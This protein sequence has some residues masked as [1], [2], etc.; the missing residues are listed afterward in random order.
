MRARNSAIARVLVRLGVE[1]LALGD[2]RCDV[3]LEHCAGVVVGRLSFDR[4]F[5]IG[6]DWGFERSVSLGD[7]RGLSLGLSMG[8][9][10]GVS[11][12]P[13]SA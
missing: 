3:V 11:M 9:R 8:L 5:G 10:L 12:G 1:A 6:V 4:T 13:G 7:S 2:D